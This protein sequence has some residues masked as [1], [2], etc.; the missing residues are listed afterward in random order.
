MGREI[1]LPVKLKGTNQS[2]QERWQQRDS[3]TGSGKQPMVGRMETPEM[4][5][6]GQETECGHLSIVAFVA[7]VC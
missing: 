6:P 1:Y 2:D 7:W 4:V 5:P 3:V